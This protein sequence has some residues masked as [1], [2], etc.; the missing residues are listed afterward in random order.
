MRDTGYSIELRADVDAE[1]PLRQGV[2]EIRYVR[3]EELLELV[4]HILTMM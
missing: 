2:V 4:C 1:V 3:V